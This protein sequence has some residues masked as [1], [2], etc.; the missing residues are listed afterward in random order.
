MVVS[1]T[2][3]RRKS[4]SREPSILTYIISLSVSLAMIIGICQFAYSLVPERSEF[5][6]TTRLADETYKG[7][8]N[9]LEAISIDRVKEIEAKED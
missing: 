7:F 9:R 1:I 3:K 2:E 8:L 5:I 4:D 6:E